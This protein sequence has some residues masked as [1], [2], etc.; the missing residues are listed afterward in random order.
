M[1]AHRAPQYTALAEL[2]G[3][4]WVGEMRWEL[5]SCGGARTGDGQRGR[6][7]GRHGSRLHRDRARYVAQAPGAIR[8]KPVA[9]PNGAVPWRLRQAPIPSRSKI[10]GESEYGLVIGG[11]M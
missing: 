4:E 1:L 6:R 9:R 5:A 7:R 11:E 8:D 2:V 10:G 3:I